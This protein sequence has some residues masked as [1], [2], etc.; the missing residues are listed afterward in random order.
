MAVVYAVTGYVVFNFRSRGRIS[1]TSPAGGSGVLD[2]GQGVIQT[3]K[4]K[5]VAG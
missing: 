2:V 4:L 5:I 1:I 3:L